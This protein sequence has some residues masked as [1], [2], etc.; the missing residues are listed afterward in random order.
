LESQ[1]ISLIEEP[2]AEIDRRRERG[3]ISGCRRIGGKAMNTA[4]K[5]TIGYNG[6]WANPYY[7]I[8]EDRGKKISIDPNVDYSTKKQAKISLKRW[9]ARLG[10][11]CEIIDETWE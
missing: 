9:I 8:I 4:Y 3:G 2:G 10:L 5:A 1:E 6:T 7:W 11:D